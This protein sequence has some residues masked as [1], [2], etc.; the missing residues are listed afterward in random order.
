VPEEGDCLPDFGIYNAMIVEMFYLDP[1]Y[2]SA[3]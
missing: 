2:P 1:T 3:G